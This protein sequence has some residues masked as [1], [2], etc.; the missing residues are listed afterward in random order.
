MASRKEARRQAID[1]LFQSDVTGADPVSVAREW[2]EAGRDV[3][4]FA[5]EL[6]E[7]VV[8]HVGEIDGLLGRFAEEWTVERMPSLDRTILRVACFELLHRADVPPAVA[9]DEAVEA[10]KSLS[11]DDSSRFVNGLLGRIAREVALG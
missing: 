3:L 8:E 7:G 10:A 11:T 5:R 1:I 2:G 6:V 9:I 4:P